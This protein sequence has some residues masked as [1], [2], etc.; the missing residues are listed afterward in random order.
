MTF[1]EVFKK[2]DPVHFNCIRYTYAV[3][4]RYCFIA[5]QYFT[6]LK[7]LS[8]EIVNRYH[9][10]VSYKFEQVQESSKVVQLLIQLCSSDDVKLNVDE[11]LIRQ[12][13]N[14]PFEFKDLVKSKEFI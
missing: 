13:P 11:K 3:I 5:L 6:E 12:I 4:T 8:K 10:F 7:N 1:V 14:F 2:C 9:D